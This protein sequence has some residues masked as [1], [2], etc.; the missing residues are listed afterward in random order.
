MSIIRLSLGLGGIALGAA[1]FWALGADS[2][3]LG[4]VL[5]AMVAEPWTLVTL[6][7]LYLGFFLIAVV[8]FAV[9]TSAVARLFW[10]IPVF[11]LGNIWSAAWLI[12]RLPVL[13]RR[14]RA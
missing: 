10:A 14:M 7:D 12:V 1:I 9:E 4:V 11:F 2:R 5:S 13:V 3:G 8:I 6:I